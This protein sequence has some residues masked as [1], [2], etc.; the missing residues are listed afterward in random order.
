MTDAAHRSR[1]LV[2]GVGNAFRRDDGVGAAAVERLRQRAPGGRAADDVQVLCLDGE[3]T[4][5]IDAWDGAERTV[6]VDAVRSGAAPG[7]V[8]RVEV[9][10]DGDDVA[11]QLPG[12]RFG[13]SSHSAGIAE[14]VALGRVLGRLPH[15][16][17]VFGVEG[18][19]FGPGPGLSPAV[20]TAL[21]TVT[22]GIAR[23]LA[24]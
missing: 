4:R 20:Q 7:T 22:D 11:S 24:G 9:D 15:R 12:S 10:L 14:A 2:I 23:E 18:E 13:A 5:L 6:V 19:D 3:P 16:L 8:Q 17:V 21:G 1:T